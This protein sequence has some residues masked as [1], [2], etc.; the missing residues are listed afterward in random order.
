MNDKRM[1]IK[2]AKYNI[3]YVY[4]KYLIIIKQEIEIDFDNT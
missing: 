2:N 1:Y 4:S 3:L